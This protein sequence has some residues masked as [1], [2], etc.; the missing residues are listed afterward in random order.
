LYSLWL[1]APS[2]NDEHEPHSSM[3][4]RCGLFA[5]TQTDMSRRASLGATA[6]CGRQCPELHAPAAP[7]KL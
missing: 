3:H 7:R 4:A 2:E 1:P 5:G 6:A